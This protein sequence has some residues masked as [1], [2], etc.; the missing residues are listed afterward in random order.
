MVPPR[1]RESSCGHCE[2][3]TTRYFSFFTHFYTISI[4]NLRVSFAKLTLSTFS[5]S[6]PSHPALYRASQTFPSGQ[7]PYARLP[8]FLVRGGDTSFPLVIPRGPL[9]PHH[10][11]VTST[12]CQCHQ[13]RSFWF[14]PP[15]RVESCSFFENGWQDGQAW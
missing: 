6:G 7:K 4:V 10:L 3:T 12:A 14:Y 9:V 11:P 5:S 8:P 13:L 2:V 15:R 1:T